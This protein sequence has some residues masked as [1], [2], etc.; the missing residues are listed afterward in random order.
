QTSTTV[1]TYTVTNVGS[2][3]TG[4]MT[5]STG[6]PQFIATGCVGTLDPNATCSITVHVKPAAAGMQTSS[7][8]VS[9][10]PG[11]T[12]PANG[13]GQGLNPAA[14]KITSAS[15]FDFGSAQRNSAGNTITF[16]ATNTGDVTSSALGHAGP[17]G[18]NASSFVPIAANDGCYMQTVAPNG[19]C[20]FQ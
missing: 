4:A 6:D 11:G 13:Q 7:V 8:Q 18:G 1:A 14:F 10:T 16:T 9:A 19:S 20:T 17:S 12:A 5:V 2:S 15:G 3:T